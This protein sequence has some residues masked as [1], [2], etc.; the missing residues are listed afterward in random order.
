METM[1]ASFCAGGVTF[2]A[3]R[4]CRCSSAASSRSISLA[5][6]Y[7]KYTA[8]VKSGELEVLGCTQ[9]VWI[10]RASGQTLLIPNVSMFPT[11]ARTAKRHT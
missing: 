10:R 8:V 2:E 9:P 5:G 3:C 4:P 11:L 7:E 6:R 1:S